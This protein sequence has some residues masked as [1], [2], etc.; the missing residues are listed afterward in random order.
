[1]DNITEIKFQIAVA[2]RKT[3]KTW[4]NIE[5]SWQ[6]FIDKAENPIR[7]NETMAEY[8]AM[9]KEEKGAKKDVGVLPRAFQRDP[10]RNLR[11]SRL[12]YFAEPSDGL[13]AENNV[14]AKA[15]FQ[16]QN[17][18]KQT[19]R[20]GRNRCIGAAEKLVKLINDNKID[21]RDPVPMAAP[22]SH[23]CVES[24][25]RHDQYL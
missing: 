21:I 4:K 17:I 24:F 5:M 13:R 25:R 7:T 15:S 14:N 9:S 1:M 22:I 3:Q 19:G 20:L 12:V 16:A 23:A 8:R 18:V 11:H 10:D 6:E 2:A